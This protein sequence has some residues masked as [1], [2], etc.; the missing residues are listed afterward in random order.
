M[1]DIHRISLIAIG[2]G[3][4]LALVTWVFF[5]DYL[6]W[7]VLGSATSLFNHSQMIHITKDK[8]ETH[9]LVLHIAQRYALYTIIIAVAWFETRDGSEDVMI[10]TFIF[11]L[12]GFVAVKVGALLY[13]T[14]LFKKDQEKEEDHHE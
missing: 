7:A 5:D 10:R 8:L 2:Y 13:A 3:L 9:R 6:L 14:P 11:L 12:L 4:V 1:R